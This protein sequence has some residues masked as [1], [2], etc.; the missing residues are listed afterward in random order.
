MRTLPVQNAIP[1]RPAQAGGL[2][3]ARIVAAFAALAVAGCTSFGG[4]QADQA[5]IDPNIAPANYKATIM[6]FLQ[7]DPTALIGVREAALS[8]PE[9]RPFGTESRY[10]SC[11]RAHGPDWSK[12]K[13]IIFFAGAINQYVDATSDACAKAAYQPFPEIV[14]LLNQLGGKKK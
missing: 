7:T 2:R 6:S 14:T 12:E 9:L 1:T 5:K 11:L 3:R 13:M 10:V 4:G 8:A